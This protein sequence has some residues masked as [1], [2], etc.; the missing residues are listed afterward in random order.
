MF[1]VET[2]SMPVFLLGEH[3]CIKATFLD[4]LVLFFF[5]FL[6]YSFSPEIMI[7]VGS[8]GK[9]KYNPQSKKDIKRLIYFTHRLTHF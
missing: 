3:G 6:N 8:G 7:I 5:F 1:K 2:R 9:Q 4:R